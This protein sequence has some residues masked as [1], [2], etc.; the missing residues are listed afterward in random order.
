S[1]W[2]LLERAATTVFPP[3]APAPNPT[4][5]LRPRSSHALHT[6]AANRR[7]ARCPVPV[8]TNTCTTP[9]PG[10]VLFGDPAIPPDGVPSDSHADHCPF[11]PRLRCAN[12][13]SD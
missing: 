13:P 7:D 6:P 3:A 1:S 5:L 12:D 4:E 9:A 10:L 11:V 8:R 2:S